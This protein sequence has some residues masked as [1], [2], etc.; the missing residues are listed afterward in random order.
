MLEPANERFFISCITT[1][2]LLCLAVGSMLY[3]DSI[4]TVVFFAILSIA[5]GVAMP[6]L[7]YGEWSKAKKI[8]LISLFIV[9]KYNINSR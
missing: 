9:L 1:Y 3:E 8:C 2:I 5:I 4:R 6:S 7:V